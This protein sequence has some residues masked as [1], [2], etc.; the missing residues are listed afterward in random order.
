MANIN[1]RAFLHSAG[2]LGFMGG[3]GLLASMTGGQAHAADV[4]GYK[5]LVCLF[6]KGGMD[7]ADTI[8]PYDQTS[9]NALQA[10]RPGVFNAYNS[11][12]AGSS[13]N[14]ANMLQLATSD[15]GGRAFALPPELAPLH[16][17]YNSGDMAVVG[18]VGPLIE[19]TTRT[20]MD[21]AGVEVPRRLFSHNDQQSTWMALDTEGSRYGWG[22]RFADAV[23]ASDGTSSPTF[24][25]ISAAGNEVFLSGQNVRQ[26]QVGSG[27][28]RD[29]NYLAQRFRLGSARNSDEVRSLLEAHFAAT[30]AADGNYFLQ[31]VAASSARAVENNR[32]FREQFGDG[33]SFAVEFPQSSLGRQLQT[34]AQTINIQ[35]FLNIRRQVFFVSTGGFDTHNNQANSLPGLHAGIAEGIA[36][37]QAAMTE[38]GMAGDVTLFTASDFGRTTIDNGDGTDHGWG[39]HHFVVGGAVNGGRI[40]GNLP[41]YELGAEYYTRSRGRLIPDVSVE[42]YAA[43]LGRWFGLDDSELLAALPNLAN[44]NERD[45]GFMNGAVV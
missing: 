45:L 36:A 13:R 7:H 23:L 8:L 40:F 43:T 34:V 16:S 44:F 39:G 4:T 26:F 6:L 41:D 18:N 21:S 2:A 1:R 25:A 29:I 17:L 15:F 14:R 22:G 30:G 19:P 12:N 5:A 28:P 35:S 27:G 32:L 20:A 38:I 10:A 9:Y 37:F 24:A 31:D 11:A 3:A 42:Q 33:G